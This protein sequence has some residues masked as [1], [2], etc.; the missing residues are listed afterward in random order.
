M[1]S[2]SYAVTMPHST[3]SSAVTSG[4]PVP[5]LS[6]NSSYSPPDTNVSSVASAL[7]RSRIATNALRTAAST[8]PPQQGLPPL[9]IP[10]ISAASSNPNSIPRP[11]SSSANSPQTGGAGYT[12]SPR[13]PSGAAGRFNNN[14][15]PV[16]DNASGYR[17]TSGPSTNNNRITQHITSAIAK[18]FSPQVVTSKPSERP[19]RTSSLLPPPRIIPNY[20]NPLAPTPETETPPAIEDLLSGSTLTFN[21]NDVKARDL[22]QEKR[23]HSRKSSSGLPYTHS[24]SSSV[25]G[26]GDTLRSL[27]RWSDSTSSSRSPQRAS[28]DRPDRERYSRRMSVEVLGRPRT[29]GSISGSS[30]GRKLQKRDRR[31]STS[32]GS[33]AQGRGEAPPQLPTQQGPRG[34]VGETLPPIGGFGASLEQEIRGESASLAGT[35]QTYTT[36]QYQDDGGY[37]SGVFKR[38]V[39]QQNG[40]GSYTT[41]NGYT[42][43]GSTSGAENGSDAGMAPRAQ[44]GDPKGHSR[45]RSQAAKSSADTTGSSRSRAGSKAPSQ[46]AMLSRALAK[47]NQAVQLDNAQSYQVAKDS[48]KEACDI[49]TAVLAKTAGEEDQRKLEAIVCAAG[50]C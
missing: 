25:G 47:A 32:A 20:A 16:Y 28:T 50:P 1:P 49:L 13:L 40:Q 45:N 2:S 46:K 48:Y 27:N 41:Q 11:G 18:G 37:F 42:T 6:S 21:T 35:P 4:S 38:P 7:P 31:P 10:S 33:P 29:G 22:K 44:N 30:P 23:R 24:R 26:L 12:R 39:P 17:G 8:P 19:P 14:N 5:P 36:R 9:P 15:S 34:F 43:Q 3:S